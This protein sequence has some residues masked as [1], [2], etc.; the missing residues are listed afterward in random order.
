RR[1]GPPAPAPAALAVAAAPGVVFVVRVVR[2]RIG[3]R[4]VRPR[5]LVGSEGG[6]RPGPGRVGRIDSAQPGAALAALLRAIF[7][8]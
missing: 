1:Q 7:R 4:R 6:F 5:A 2:L 3:T 8:G